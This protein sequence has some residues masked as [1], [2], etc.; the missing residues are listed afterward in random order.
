MGA[1]CELNLS[2]DSKFVKET[3]DQITFKKSENQVYRIKHQKI[4]D[5]IIQSIISNDLKALERLTKFSN[6]NIYIEQVRGFE[7]TNKKIIQSSAIN[8]NMLNPL[9]FA[10]MYSKLDALKLL[11]DA[12]QVNYNC[13]LSNTNFKNEMTEK[14]NNLYP[15]NGHQLTLIMVCMNK[16]KKMLTYLL[17]DLYLIWDWQD[18]K[19]L[20]KSI[21]K[22]QWAEGIPIMFQSCAF[23][24]LCCSE[25][26]SNL[27]EI[28]RLNVLEVLDMYPSYGHL[29]EQVFDIVLDQV[30]SRV[31]LFYMMDYRTILSRQVQLSK[32]IQ[33]IS[34]QDVLSDS[35]L[36]QQLLFTL[37]EQLE[38]HE[39]IYD[40]DQQNIL[41]ELQDVIRRYQGLK[42]VKFADVSAE[43]MHYIAEGL[44]KKV[45]ETIENNQIYDACQIR[46]NSSEPLQFVNKKKE[47]LAVI[48]SESEADFCIVN[49]LHLALFY[50]RQDILHYFVSKMKVN[51]M[52]AIRDPIN[53]SKV[54]FLI[55]LAYVKRNMKLFIGIWED[56]AQLF[57]YCDLLEA[58]QL[59][60]CN[61]KFKLRMLDKL[62]MSRNSIAIFLNLP[63]KK[64]I[65]FIKE[66]FDKIQQIDLTLSEYQDTDSSSIQFLKSQSQSQVVLNKHT[67]LLVSK[68]MPPIQKSSFNGHKMSMLTQESTPSDF[69]QIPQVKNS[70]VLGATNSDQSQQ[71]AHEDTKK[72]FELQQRSSKLKNQ[73]LIMFTKQPFSLCTLLLSLEVCPDIF[74]RSLLELTERDVDDFMSHLPVKAYKIYSTSKI[75]A[76]SS[77]LEKLTIEQR[78]FYHAVKDE[79][80][81]IA[82]KVMN[83][84][85]FEQVE[86]AFVKQKGQ[87]IQTK[88]QAINE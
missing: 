27:I 47:L 80:R 63:L 10:V 5:D 1:C 55:N 17:N 22:D 57:G 9:M 37:N 43:I 35:N 21:F 74:K 24:S 16:D 39:Y 72:N 32:I 51:L 23:K 84:P 82:V 77:Y 31:L 60:S 2:K 20:L 61:S 15:E 42:Q 69:L 34:Q 36:Y 40:E 88:G 19:R 62:L 67:P 79:Y 14:Q 49:A 13:C 29:I 68:G 12:T 50:E 11:N 45:V 76:K 59:L 58:I 3:L 6:S 46:D 73:L 8:V 4:Y 86:Q 70:Y 44:F 53:G 28:F 48:G 33:N 81:Q 38:D 85:L 65:I 25:D 71:L 78:E 54:K 18:F 83:H 64:R 7:G 75:F 56:Y 41:I 52:K 66:V 87:S 26:L 30:Y